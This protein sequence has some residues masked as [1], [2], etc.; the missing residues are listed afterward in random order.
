MHKVKLPSQPLF[1]QIHLQVFLL[2]SAR[3]R[4]LQKVTER[5]YFTYSLRIPHPTKLN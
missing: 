2:M 3:K 1:V 4:A 5:L